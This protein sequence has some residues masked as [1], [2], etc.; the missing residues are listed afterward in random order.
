M[1][2]I[3]HRDA[4]SLQQI[5]RQRLQSLE[6]VDREPEALWRLVGDVPELLQVGS[7]HPDAK[8]N[9]SVPPQALSGYYH[10]VR[11]VPVC[12]DHSDLRHPLV[13][14]TP[15]LL[16]E[17]RRQEEVDGLACFRAS[18]PVGKVVH[19]IQQGCLVHVILQQEL[20]KSFITVL[21]QADPN[22]VRADVEACDGA[23][24][25]SPDLLKV[26]DADAGGAVDQEDDISHIGF[27]TVC[28]GGRK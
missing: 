8:H 5:F 27:G 11:G 18:C 26:T 1:P 13:G 15:G 3:L 19:C 25:K 28:T 10:I 24:E 20:L 16:G 9:D 22:F 7:S 23:F 21:S 14:S 2:L 17:I 4:N 6:A 12:D